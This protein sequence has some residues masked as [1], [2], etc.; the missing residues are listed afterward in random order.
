MFLSQAT[1]AFLQSDACNEIC[2]VSFAIIN[3]TMTLVHNVAHDCVFFFFALFLRSVFLFCSFCSL[4]LTS[5]LTKRYN[6]NAAI[7]IKLHTNT[8]RQ[9]FYNS[10]RVEWSEY[11]KVKEVGAGWLADWLQHLMA[12]CINFIS[13][14]F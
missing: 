10:N 9:E 7:I 5:L 14:C 11:A 13:S 8:K 1:R 12:T 4:C 3:G 2:T 6:K